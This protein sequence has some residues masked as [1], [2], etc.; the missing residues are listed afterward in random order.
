L[1][2]SEKSDF[3]KVIFRFKKKKNYNGKF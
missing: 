1:D 2:L 3:Q